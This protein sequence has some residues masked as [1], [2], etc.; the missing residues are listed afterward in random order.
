MGH[1]LQAA[2]A[3]VEVGARGGTDQLAPHMLAKPVER[4]ARKASG[5]GGGLRALPPREDPRRGR[6]VDDASQDG[7]GRGLHR[8]LVQDGF[9]AFG[10]HVAVPKERL[11]L[12]AGSG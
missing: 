11:D 4:D 9:G 5:A 3:V 12:D 10:G 6:A 2:Q 1:V 8:V 7:I